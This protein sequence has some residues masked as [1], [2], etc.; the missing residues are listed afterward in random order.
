MTATE[1]APQRKGSA[2]LFWEEV[3]KILEK[4]PGEILKITTYNHPTVAY[5]MRRDINEGKNPV[6]PEVGQWVA[7]VSKDEENPFYGPR[8]RRLTYRFDFFMVYIPSTEN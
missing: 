3:R 8:S 1:T 6:F 7:T 5:R 4:K 2:Q